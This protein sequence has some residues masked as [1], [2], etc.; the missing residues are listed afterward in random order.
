MPDTTDPK[1]APDVPA[2]PQT[3]GGTEPPKKP[4]TV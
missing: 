3:G 1:P 4:P 2:T